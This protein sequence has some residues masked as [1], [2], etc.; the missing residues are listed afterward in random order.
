LLVGNIVTIVG[1]IDEMS[2][3][4]DRDHPF[5]SSKF[6]KRFGYTPVTAEK[7]VTL[8]LEALNAGA[9]LSLYTQNKLF[10]YFSNARFKPMYC[11]IRK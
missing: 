2:Y 3:R 9:A 11:D 6:E 10:F 7:G 4:Y 5:D 8:A 1:K